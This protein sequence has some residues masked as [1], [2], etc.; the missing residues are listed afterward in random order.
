M[1]TGARPD[2]AHLHNFLQRVDPGLRSAAAAAEPAAQ[3]RPAAAAGTA[4]AAGHADGQLLQRD[5]GERGDEVEHR[6]VAQARGG[7]EQS[8]QRERVERGGDRLRVA[9]RQ[10]DS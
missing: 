8:L 4:A 7:V 5:G 9:L 10:I 6:A 2:R 3:R 1:H